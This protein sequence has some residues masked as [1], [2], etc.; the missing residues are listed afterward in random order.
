MQKRLFSLFVFGLSVLGIQ[1]KA[2]AA[3]NYG[4]W[5]ITVQVQMELMPTE[6]PQEVFQKC[7]SRD[8]L[9]PGGNQDKSG[10]DKDKVTVKG[11]TVNW[12]VKC[13]HE[14]HTMTGTG[15]VVYTE[16][17]LTG[18]AQFQI[19]GVDLATMN[20]TLRYKGRRLGKCK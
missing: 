2:V 12:T 18:H 16:D 20:M 10:C 15:L 5:E 6:F 13:E 8:D 3:I 1:P 7:I 17:N 19:G 9:T 11:D 14:D 4:L